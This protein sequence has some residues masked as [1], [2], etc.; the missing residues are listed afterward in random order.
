MEN[1]RGP[2]LGDLASSS[3]SLTRPLRMLAMLIR[4][5]GSSSSGENVLERGSSCEWCK[6][7]AG[8]LMDGKPPGISVE[9]KSTSVIAAG[10]SSGARVECVLLND[11]T[12]GLLGLMSLVGLSSTLV[13]LSFLSCSGDVG[14]RLCALATV[15]SEAIVDAPSPSSVIGPELADPRKAR[16]GFRDGRIG[17]GLGPTVTTR[18]PDAAEIICGRIA[19]IGRARTCCTSTT[20]T[21]PSSSSSRSRSSNSLIG[22][23][24]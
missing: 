18:A 1:L 9:P 20:S 14:E 15:P 5:L 12:D 4:L 24:G 3:S 2:G 23:V 13:T 6:S 11:L 22:E 8:S 17:V 21:V 19:C 10:C 16:D 7:N